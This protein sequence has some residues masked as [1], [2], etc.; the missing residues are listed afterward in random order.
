MVWEEGHVKAGELAITF[1]K[2][3]YPVSV[4]PSGRPCSKALMISLI[5]VLLTCLQ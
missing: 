2:K 5:K 1:R 4:F 3:L